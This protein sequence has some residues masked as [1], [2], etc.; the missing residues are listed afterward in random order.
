[1]RNTYLWLAQLATGLIIL[2]VIGIHVVAQHPQGIILIMQWFD[3][4]SSLASGFSAWAAT[5]KA[6][7]WGG[8]YVTVIVLGL[9][10]GV[11]GLRGRIMELSPAAR[12]KRFVTWSIVVAGVLIAAVVL[13]SRW[14]AKA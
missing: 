7:L 8:L 14:L 6:N 12:T 4:K 1:M 11:N 5:A 2:V 13:M 10:H 9:F 3:S